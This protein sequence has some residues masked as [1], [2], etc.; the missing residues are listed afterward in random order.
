MLIK[1]PDQWQQQWMKQVVDEHCK[2]P[3]TKQHGITPQT[4]KRDVVKSIVNI[5]ELIAQAS[6]SK[7]EK[8]VQKTAPA[9]PQDN[10]TRIIQLEEQMKQAAERLDFETAIALR[11]EWQQLKKLLP[12]P[13]VE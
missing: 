5:Q 8:K 13:L 1:L 9:H 4:V 6:K 11:A 12:P 7:K 10:A 3:T 2:L